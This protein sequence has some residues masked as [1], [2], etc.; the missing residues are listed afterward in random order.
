MRFFNILARVI[1][2]IFSLLLV[3]IFL[4]MLTYKEENIKICRNNISFEKNNYQKLEHILELKVLNNCDKIS[5]LISLSEKVNKEN[6][7]GV[8][9]NIISVKRIYNDNEILE[10]FIENN[11][12]S[13]IVIIDEEES[14]DIDFTE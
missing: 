9:L 4:V 5:L 8:I 14:F 10:L 6:I 7:N 2:S 11:D 13:C 3:S 12:L 1:L